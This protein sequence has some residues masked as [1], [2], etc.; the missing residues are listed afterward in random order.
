MTNEEYNG[1][2]A[3]AGVG[4]SLLG[5]ASALLPNLM[6]REL[7]DNEKEQMKSKTCLHC[8]SRP[9][10]LDCNI[11]GR[12]EIDKQKAKDE[13][14]ALVEQLKELNARRLFLQLELAKQQK[15]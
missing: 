11:C 9:K 3:T 15:N 4:L 7:T 14:D 10:K 2:M 8:S 5:K 13:L 12:Y 6:T 1:I